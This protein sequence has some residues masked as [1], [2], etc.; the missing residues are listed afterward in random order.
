MVP[1]EGGAS[2][3]IAQQ[4]A[5]SRFARMRLNVP[6]ALLN[7]VMLSASQYAGRLGRKLQQYVLAVLIA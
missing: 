4:V 2:K 1:S 5:C 7:P 3:R 6:A